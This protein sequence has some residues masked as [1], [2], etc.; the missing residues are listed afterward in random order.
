[1]KKIITILLSLATFTFCAFADDK[2][3]DYEQLPSAAKTFVKAEFPALSVLYVTRDTDL[4]DTTYDVHFTNGLKIEF[5]SRGEWKEISTKTA[6]IDSKYIPRQII[7]AVATRWPGE[8][9][10]KI[11]RYKYSYE[12][13]LTNSLELKF[14]KKFRLT[15]I[16][17]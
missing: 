17:D 16:D 12:V 7:D 3:I 11:E 10:K 1:M 4:L 2:P 8:K 6:T 5:N 9:F 15:E 13:E 14:D